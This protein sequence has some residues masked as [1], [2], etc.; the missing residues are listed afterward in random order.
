MNEYKHYFRSEE[1]VG[2]SMLHIS[3][4]ALYGAIERLTGDAAHK[5]QGRLEKMG[6]NGR[7]KALLGQIRNLENTLLETEPDPDH[8][9]GLARKV[10]A[11]QF[12]LKAA[13]QLRPEFH[14]ITGNDMPYG[15]PVAGFIDPGPVVPRQ[16]P[17]TFEQITKYL[18]VSHALPGPIMLSTTPACPFP[19]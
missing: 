10:N 17:S 11:Y 8:R 14:V 18:F 19:D 6:V 15:H 2:L 1:C 3:A 7:V 5:G 4:V 12:E 16:P 9:E 13:P